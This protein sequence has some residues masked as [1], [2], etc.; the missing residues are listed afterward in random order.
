MT[1]AGH[2][3]M[4][5]PAQRTHGMLTHRRA[6][7][8]TERWVIEAEPAVQVLARRVFPGA[9]TRDRDGIYFSGTRRQIEDLLWLMTRYPLEMSTETREALEQQ[10]HAAVALAENR[11]SRQERQAQAPAKFTG[12][13]KP[14]QSTGLGFLLDNPRTILAD[15]MGLGKTVQL[16]AAAAAAGRWPVLCVVPNSV[17]SQWARMIDAFLKPKMG[18]WSQT[19]SGTRT[20]TAIPTAPFYIIHY[21]LVRYWQD[22]LL[23]LAPRTVIFDE[24][25]ELRR[26]ESQKYSACHR[27]SE[28]A[29][30]C[31]GASGTPIYNYGEEIWW[32]LNAIDPYCLGSLEGFT[33]EWCDGYMGKMIADPP[34]LGNY[35]K[36]EGLL[37]RRR[38]GEVLTELP[39][40]RRVV[41]YI[42]HDGSTFDRLIERVA[43]M[44]RGYASIKDHLE[45]GRTARMIEQE[46]RQATGI[47]KAPSAAAFIMSLL[48]AG[49]RPIVF[50]H[51]HTVHQTILQ[52]LKNHDHDGTINARLVTGEETK[53]QKDEAVREFSEGKARAI[54]LALRTA[55]GIDGL[56]RNGT[57]VVFAELDWSPAIHAQ[58]EDR[59]NRM[60]IAEDADST[61]CYYLVCSTGTDA[62]MMSALGLKVGQ[63]IGLMGDEAES[64]EDQDE[65]L[66]QGERRIGEL[67]AR[68][69]GG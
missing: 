7:D 31:W 5:D 58:C 18:S 6:K 45:R 22:R 1:I 23:A 54:I 46:A 40:K 26:G 8:G 28:Q 11:E 57:V 50:A 61:L 35:L 59:L 38:K 15:D 36:R 4:P 48:D 53:A 25:Q 65:A 2:L 20:H 37:L 67:I 19:L 62:T 16:I 24:C 68:L 21:G 60:G 56:Q 34:A 47:A 33:R 69:A 27:V 12:T 9:N 29:E 49:E 14:F 44:A 30:I 64:T 63:F 10:R 3:T 32:V 41:Q 51:H 43:T 66:R 13:L 42:D 52:A 55:A 17:T 39:R